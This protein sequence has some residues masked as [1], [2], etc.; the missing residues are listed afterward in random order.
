MQQCRKQKAKPTTLGKAGGHCLGGYREPHQEVGKRAELL[1]QE[2]YPPWV[3]RLVQIYDDS[4][5]KM[6]TR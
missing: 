4:K 3:T 5:L 2:W 6:L 1:S